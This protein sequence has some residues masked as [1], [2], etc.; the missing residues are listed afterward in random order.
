MS[1]ENDYRNTFQKYFELNENAKYNLYKLQ[2][3]M[4][5]VSN[6]IKDLKQKS[7]DIETLEKGKNNI[8]EKLEKE[9]QNS[10]YIQIIQPLVTTELPKN[11][12]IKRN[13]ALSSVVGLFAMLF[14]GFFLEYLS[15]YKRMN[16]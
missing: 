4:S 3:K 2:K 15:K 9:K 11:N 8:I 7:K 16:K 5:A 1:I 13:V 12:K 6:E 14:L 10:Q